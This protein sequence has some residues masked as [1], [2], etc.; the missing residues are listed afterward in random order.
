MLRQLS[1]LLYATLFSCCVAAADSYDAATNVLSIP[2]V[3]V[4]GFTLS[5]CP[6]D[7]GYRE[8]TF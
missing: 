1:V 3:K 2:L 8:V 4:G 5:I 7:C 6:S